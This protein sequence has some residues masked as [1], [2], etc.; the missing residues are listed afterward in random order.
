M[1]IMTEEKEDHK[2][3]LGYD[4][5]NE[6]FAHKTVVHATLAKLGVSESEL[7]VNNANAAL[8][9]IAVWIGSPCSAAGSGLGVP[10]HGAPEWQPKAQADG[11]GGGGSKQPEV[12]QEVFEAKLRPGFVSQA[13]LLPA[14]A[15]GAVVEVAE[16][17]R[18]CFVPERAAAFWSLHVVCKTFPERRT[19]WAVYRTFF[20]VFMTNLVA[21]HVMMAQVR[22]GGGGKAAGGG[23]GGVRGRR[24]GVCVCAGS[25]YCRGLGGHNLLGG[26]IVQQLPASPQRLCNHLVP[27]T[28]PASPQ[29]PTACMPPPL[30]SNTL[31]ASLPPPIHL[32]ASSIQHPASLSLSPT[33]CSACPTAGSGVCCPVQ[34]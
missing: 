29:H 14:L 18:C 34:C 19:W 5:I 7:S 30:S 27:C 25:V 9:A 21:F 6:S 8:C 20:R 33:C 11:R 16:G 10:A 22:P 3:R 26:C 15:P 4:D 32:Y 31:N 17:T 13:R 2:H 1:E 28:L 24:G 12:Q 23:E